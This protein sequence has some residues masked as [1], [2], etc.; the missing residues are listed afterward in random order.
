MALSSKLGL[1]LLVAEAEAE[2]EAEPPSACSE[3]FS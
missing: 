1:T 2:A 3:L